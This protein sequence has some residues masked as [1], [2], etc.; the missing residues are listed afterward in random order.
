MN[1]QININDYIEGYEHF[2]INIRKVRGWVD[3]ISLDEEGVYCNIQ[4]DDEYHGHRGAVI[5]EKLG[6]ITKLNNKPRPSL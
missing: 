3:Y 2:G 4:A 1:N 6:V 5:F